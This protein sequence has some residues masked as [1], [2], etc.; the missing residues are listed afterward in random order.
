MKT[1]QVEL[2]ARMKVLYKSSPLMRENIDSEERKNVR[3]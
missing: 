1:G 3:N 2:D